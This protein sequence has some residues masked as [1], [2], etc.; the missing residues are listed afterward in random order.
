MQIGNKLK[1]LDVAIKALAI[2]KKENVNFRLNVIG[3][4][5]PA[6]WDALVSDY[7]MH[8][9]IVFHEAVGSTEE[10]LQWLDNMDLYI[11]PSRH[12]GLPRAMIEAMSR[13]LPCLGSNAGG[14]DELIPQSCIHKMG[15]YKTLE[16]HILQIHRDKEWFVEQATANIKTADQYVDKKLM[17]RRFAFY[18][19]LAD[20]VRTR[21]I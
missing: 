13:G 9:H 2:L 10:I 19:R 8:N 20:L 14:I 5:D 7:H 12:E 4:G 11:Q 21:H 17:P 3:L 15:D 6:N 1:G 16:K 18:Q